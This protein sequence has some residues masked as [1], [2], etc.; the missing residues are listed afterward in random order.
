MPSTKKELLTR[1][2]TCSESRNW[3]RK[4]YISL[5]HNINLM[6][7]RDPIFWNKG[8]IIILRWCG[9]GEELKKKSNSI[10]SWHTSINNKIIIRKLLVKLKTL[11]LTDLLYLFLILPLVFV[12]QWLAD[13]CPTSTNVFSDCWKVD[14]CT[15]QKCHRVG[16]N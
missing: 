16:Q 8:H 13:E 7:H 5:S 2:I 3:C 9:G 4:H 14:V 6:M 1:T 12:H 10:Q 11:F 15:H